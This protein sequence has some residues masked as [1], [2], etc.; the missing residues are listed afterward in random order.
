MRNTGNV[1]SHD[2]CY[3]RATRACSTKI[4]GEHLVS[5]GVLKILAEKEVELS[6]TPWLKG[7]KKKFGFAALTANCL[8][9]V[10]NTALS[11]IDAGGALFFNAIQKCGTSESGAAHNF[12]LSG[13]DVERWL[14]RTLVALGV[15]K[16]LGLGGAALD[17]KLVERLR[18]AELLEDH[19]QWKQPLGLYLM[20]GLGYKFT[21]RDT[22]DVA[23]LIKRGSDDVLGLWSNIQGF[24]LGLLATDHDISGTGLD[25]ALYRPGAF[26]FKIGHKTH[27]LRLSWEDDL[28]HGDVTLTW[29]N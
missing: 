9:T 10:H 12:L 29:E 14:F 6:G 16:N 21:R 18:I 13:H 28:K 2:G 8:C 20:Q 27:T 22:L 23:P 1:G 25:K 24:E 3:L 5:E 19:M 4:S 7:A 15:S 26:I 11:P 17:N